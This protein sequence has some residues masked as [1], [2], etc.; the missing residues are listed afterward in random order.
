MLSNE[1]QS[2]TPKV[3]SM[4]KEGEKNVKVEEDPAK[5]K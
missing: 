1:K 2:R 3:V 4:V 5:A